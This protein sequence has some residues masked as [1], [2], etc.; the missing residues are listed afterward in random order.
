MNQMIPRFA[1]FSLLV[2]L[3]TLLA[4]EQT[5]NDPTT[6]A[7]ASPIVDVADGAPLR[8]PAF[9]L[10]SG[11]TVTRGDIGCAVI[12]GNG[13]WFP[14]SFDLPCGTEVATFSRNGNAKVTVQASGAPNPTGKTVHWGPYNPGP[15]WIASYPELSEPPYPCFLLGTD[16]DLENP[17]FTVKW[18]ATVTPSGEATLT[19]QFSTKWE[20]QW[21]E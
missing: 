8:A 14:Q 3:A 5:P 13:E 12:D 16:H 1:A 15:D 19:C 17:L 4:C 11:A 20:F 7:M 10:N 9:D 6:D 21:P 2:G 18:H